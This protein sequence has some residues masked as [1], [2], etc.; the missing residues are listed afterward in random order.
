[1]GNTRQATL[2]SLL[3]QIPTASQYPRE[4]INRSTR[5]GVLPGIK[6][7]TISILA[8]KIG[9]EKNN[10]HFEIS[11]KVTNKRAPSGIRSRRFRNR[12]VG[13]SIISKPKS[14]PDCPSLGVNT[15]RKSEGR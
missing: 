6:L 7:C 4:F 9:P 11:G 14:A 15:V 5:S 13:P 10:F 12:S 1:V 2:R 3:Q 8:D